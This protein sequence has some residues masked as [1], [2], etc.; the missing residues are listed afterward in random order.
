MVRAMTP[1]E[2]LAKG[3]EDFE[4]GDFAA[5]QSA[6]DQALARDENTPEAH[7]L[8]GLCALADLDGDLAMLRFER[9]ITL[10]PDYVDPKLHAA[11]MLIADGD[12]ERALKFAEEAL[13]VAE[14][15]D[16]FLDALL[17]KAGI[18]A[19][20][21]DPDAAA[22]TLSELPPTDVALPDLAFHLRAAE[23][24][25]AI[26][27]ADQ[28]E[29]HY[30]MV[31]KSDPKLADA[32][33]GLGLC[34]EAR[35]EDEEKVS[36]FQETR[37]LDAAAEPS[38]TP[39]DRAKLEEIVERTL[40]EL[41]ERARKLL[42]NV[43]VLVEDAPSEELVAEGTDPRVLGLFAGVPFPEKSSM[44]GAPHLDQVLLFKRNLENHCGSADEL[45]EEVRTTI[46]HETGH[47]FGLDEEDLAKL[48]LD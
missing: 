39:I 24:F 34:A 44:G 8:L 43:P 32:H 25:L 23:I 1:E 15:E 22:S 10:D 14:E 42:G 6:G 35:G 13:D 17:L 3:F 18:E 31:L 40:R 5:A 2:L 47:F 9:A 11:E 29:A 38:Q 19:D 21:E 12:L 26:E 16:D 48:G 28:A 30:R 41:P 4:K 45:E 36:H 46:L 7:V 20:L 37:R 33:Y 27:D